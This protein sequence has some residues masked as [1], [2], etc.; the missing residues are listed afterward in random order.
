VG[1]RHQPCSDGLPSPS[2]GYLCGLDLS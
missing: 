1:F 2:A